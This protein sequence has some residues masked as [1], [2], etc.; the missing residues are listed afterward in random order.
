MSV[1]DILERDESRPAY[2][3]FELRA[4]PDKEASL[5]AGHHVSRDVH[6]ALVTPAYSKDL[7]EQ[8][9]NTWLEKQEGLVKAGRVPE[10]HLRY[11]KR[12]YEN[13]KEGLEPP[14]NGTSIKEWNILSPAQ[15][16]NLLAAGCR[17]IED[18]AQ[19]NDEALRRIGMGAVDLKNKAK[20]YLQAAKD[21]GPLTM[22]VSSLQKENE[23]LKGTIESMQEQ[24]KMMQMQM[25]DK[26]EEV[27]EELE[28]LRQQ[29][30]ERF[31]N[32]PHWRMKAPKLRKILEA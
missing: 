13:F 14:V 17:T 10:D 27:D 8:E 11:W 30:K 3:R 26:E 23:Q 25:D 6:Y 24:I 32:D 5:K 29:Y 16:T 15:C 7:F 9:A 18:M 22:Q 19:A 21:H 12:V 20:A 2:V 31:G 1:G 4:V 28:T